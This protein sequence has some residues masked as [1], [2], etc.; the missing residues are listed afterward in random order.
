MA[1]I[2]AAKNDNPLRI[3]ILLDGGANLEGQDERKRTA[4]S[5]AVIENAANAIKTLLRR[6]AIGLV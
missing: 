3:E 6:G 2:M 5:W 1:L 4:L